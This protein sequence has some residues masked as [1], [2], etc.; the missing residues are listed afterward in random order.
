METCFFCKNG[1]LEE[2][3]VTVYFMGKQVN[4]H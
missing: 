1:A 2:K 3:K 4:Y